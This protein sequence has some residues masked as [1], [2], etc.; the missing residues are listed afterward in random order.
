MQEQSQ[1]EA[2][3]VLKWYFT[4]NFRFTIKLH[5][6][7]GYLQF[8]QERF[9]LRNQIRDAKLEGLKNAWN[10]FYGKLNEAN[11][12]IRN[13]KIA[14]IIIEIGKVDPHIKNAVLEEYLRCAQRVHT[15]AFLQWRLKFPSP[16]RDND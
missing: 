4:F 6:T 8:I 7:I 14:A 3:A 13:K 16:L 11:V 2:R 9:Y 15:I 10:K 12:Q 1:D 5:Q